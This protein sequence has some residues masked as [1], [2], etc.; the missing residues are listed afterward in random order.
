WGQID[1]LDAR[2]RHGGSLPRTAP[3]SS[4][5]GLRFEPGDWSASVSFKHVSSA[6][7]LA[8]NESQTDGYDWLSLHLERRWQK[9]G[10]ELQVWLK[11]ENLQ[12]SL[13]Y[14][15]L[16]P[17]KTSAPLPGRQVSLGVNWVF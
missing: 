7:K 16:S 5:I 12:D 3:T 10:H 15:H 17:L 6:R 13:A 9:A 14:N 8:D 1:L 4:E 2:R 11:G